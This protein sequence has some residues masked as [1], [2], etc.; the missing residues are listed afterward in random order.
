M[1]NRSRRPNISVEKH[2]QNHSKQQN[3]AFLHHHPRGQRCTR[4]FLKVPCELLAN[5][6]ALEDSVPLLSLVS[7]NAKKQICCY[8]IIQIYAS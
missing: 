4:G 3:C 2:Q 6:R 7:R 8:S 5:I 1:A